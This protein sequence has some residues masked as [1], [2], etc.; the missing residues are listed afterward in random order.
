MPEIQPVVRYMVPCEE[1]EIA[2]KSINLQRLVLNLISREEPPYPILYPE[3]C[4]FVVLTEVRGRGSFAVRIVRADSDQVV[5]STK[6]YSQS[7]GADPLI[8]HGLPFRLRD[9]EFPQAGLYWMS[10]GSTVLFS[11]NRICS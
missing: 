4:L 2:G 10:F 8:A 9:C 11:P 5:F 7:F 6:E 1:M 3:L